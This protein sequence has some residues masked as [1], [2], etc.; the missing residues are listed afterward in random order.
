[1]VR[2]RPRFLAGYRN[3]TRDAYALDLRQFVTWCEQHGWHPPPSPCA[4]RADGPHPAG[5]AHRSGDRLRDRRAGRRTDLS[6]PQRRAPSPSRGLTDLALPWTRKAGIAKTVGQH[7]LRHAFI[8][9]ASHAGVP[10]CD[11]QDA[12][13]HADRRTT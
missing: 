13:S 6:G 4:A 5:T 2:A 11:V 8:S 1:M 9:A 12:A 3:L 7:T 10:L